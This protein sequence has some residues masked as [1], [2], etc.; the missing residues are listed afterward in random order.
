MNQVLCVCNFPEERNTARVA[1]DTRIVR[2]LTV[3]PR[4]SGQPPRFADINGGS[5][6]VVVGD[7]ALY[8]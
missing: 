6:N 2:P 4:R 8:L 5:F 1:A 7:N 3:P